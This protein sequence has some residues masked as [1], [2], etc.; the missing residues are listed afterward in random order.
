MAIANELKIMDED[1]KLRKLKN[2][3]DEETYFTYKI[4]KAK[5]SEL[6]EQMKIIINKKLAFKTCLVIVENILQ[7]IHD[8][9]NDW[10]LD[11][12][13]PVPW[14]YGIFNSYWL[15]STASID[16]HDRSKNETTLF[17]Q[18]H[19]ICNLSE[20]IELYW[21][22][23]AIMELELL[24]VAKSI[25][26]DPPQQLTIVMD[27]VWSCLLYSQLYSTRD[28]EKNTK[29]AS[30]SKNYVRQKELVNLWISEGIFSRIPKVAHITMFE[31][32][33]I[34]EKLK[35]KEEEVNGQHELGTKHFN[36][37][38]D[39]E[40]LLRA[41]LSHSL[42]SEHNSSN[43]YILS[44]SYASCI[45]PFDL[46]ELLAEKIPW[47]VNRWKLIEHTSYEE[48]VDKSWL[49]FFDGN[50]RWINIHPT[51]NLSTTLVLR[52][53]NELS[54]FSLEAMFSLLKNLRVLDLSYT[55]IE[56]IPFSLSKMIN[57]RFLSLRGCNQLKTLTTD[58]SS[59]STSSPFGPLEHIEFLDLGETSLNTVPDDVV[60]SK[61]K[62]HYL[63]FSCTHITSMPCLFFQDVSSSLKELLFLGCTL[64]ESLPSSLTNLFNLETFSLSESQLISLPIETFELMPKLQDL[65]LINNRQLW[66]LPK[67]AGHASLKSFNLSGSPITNLSLRACQSLETV[68]LNDLNQL[69][70]LDL[71]ATAIKEF[72]VSV[73]ELR[74]LKRLDL[75]VLPQLRRLPWHKMQHIPEVFNLD[76][77]Q[78]VGARIFL[79][80]SKLFS[81]F[82]YE[83]CEHLVEEKGCLQ[84]FHILVSSY[85][86]TRSKKDEECIDFTEHEFQNIKKPSCYKDIPLMA[87][88]FKQQFQPSPL[89]KR[90]IEIFSPNR[91]PTGLKGILEVTESLSLWDD[92]FISSLTDLN[93]RFPQLKECKLRECHHMDSIFKANKKIQGNKLQIIWAF[94]IQ[95]M[96]RI[97]DQLGSSP[98]FVSSEFGALKH[99][100]LEKCPRLESI[101]PG[102]VEL[103]SLETLSVLNCGNLRSIFYYHEVQDENQFPRLHT[104][105]LHEL[106]NLLHLCEKQSVPL[107]M[108]EWKKFHFR[109]CWNLQWLPLLVGARS[110]KVEVD[111]EMRQ[112]EKL[113]ARM[114]DDQISCYY[115][116]SPPPLA[117]FREHVKNKIFLKY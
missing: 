24:H 37:E 92:A 48:W 104:M 30:C 23:A 86:N 100:H 26:C 78:R 43:V 16:C 54:K 91:Y 38:F 40:K 27:V 41:L 61:T 102:H 90:H 17:L 76:Q 73:I 59:N 96:T 60:K 72:P 58:F 114:P 29:E 93:N 6:V 45:V 50:G 33:G 74:R 108:K 81:C 63:D 68:C 75:L 99:V 103:S 115:F 4:N 1:S 101:F 88:T 69:E 79:T 12:G 55:S 5:E 94:D 53:C 46:R 20:L 47:L 62:L 66:S 14:K 98:Y 67:L 77:F 18:N 111:G 31:K 19:Y 64:L 15:I 25:L 57:L 89:L 13:L 2:E 21:H 80:D 7:P 34:F 113:R 109:G 49:S 110:E 107:H 106:P 11:S 51:P 71:S 85:N 116:K 28:H 84:S 117:S 97:L 32:G 36:W 10:L 105:Q 42:L 56:Q 44:S 35:V 82:T 39:E 112:C 95:K 83:N 70:E 8:P 87:R 65:N 52:G 22:P 9:A 3:L